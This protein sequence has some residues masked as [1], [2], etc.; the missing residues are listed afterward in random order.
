[1]FNKN[2][3]INKGVVSL[4][5]G[6]LFLRQKNCGQEQFDYLS[7]NKEISSKVIDN[8]INNI[9]FNVAYCLK[10]NI[11]Y[12]HIVFPAK[13]IA[14][15]E[16]LALAGPSIFPIFS[17]KHALP[18]VFYP[19]LETLRESHY[20]KYDSHCSFLGSRFIVGE[21]LKKID[22]NICDY[23]YS[24]KSIVRQGDLSAMLGLPAKEEV[25]LNLFD[26]HSDPGVNFSLKKALQKNSGEIIFNLNIQAPIKKRVVLFG[27]SF[28]VGA[29]N[30][31]RF[32]IEEIIYIRSPYIIGDIANALSPD[33]ILTGNAER[34]LVNVP[35][36]SANSLF[37]M[38]FISHDYDTSKLTENDIMGF[39]LLFL[40]RKNKNYTEWKSSFN[41]KNLLVK[42]DN[43]LL[44]LMKKYSQVVDICR[45]YSLKIEKSNFKLAYR[46]M[47]LCHQARPK[48]PYIT[49]K[50]KEYQEK[51][52]SL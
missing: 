18:S 15:R 25:S 10:S 37:F 26:N 9:K 49:A 7:R 36:K 52:K 35:D 23:P 2:V 41:I 19:N 48:G 14:Y 33:V 17:D 20:F 47:G 8:F 22:I 51:S 34:Y 16:K 44:M 43:E 38:N 11:K 50:L 24:L 39:N 45:D 30:W 32:L 46:F 6:T 29:I 4:D 21:A 13:P 3:N 40:G 27:D 1:M 5:D 28:F 31:L 42:T 12:Q